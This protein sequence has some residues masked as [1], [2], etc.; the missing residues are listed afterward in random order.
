M[1]YV[2]SRFHG[3]YLGSKNDKKSPKNGSK[4]AQ[5]I[6][7]K[8]LCIYSG[9][10]YIKKKKIIHERYKKKINKIKYLSISNTPYYASCN[11]WLN[12]LEINK[13]SSKKAPASALKIISN[14]R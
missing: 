10:K 14:P 13:N 5:Y 8:M 12:I 6:G 4:N 7:G 3:R 9:I 11:F 2:I 1:P